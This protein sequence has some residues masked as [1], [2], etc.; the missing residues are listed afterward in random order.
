M[1]KQTTKKKEKEEQKGRKQTERE[2]L[3]DILL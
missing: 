2:W 1:V 3:C